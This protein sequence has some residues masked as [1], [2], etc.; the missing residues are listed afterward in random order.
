MNLDSSIIQTEIQL[1]N[2]VAGVSKAVEALA[3]ELP[4]ERRVE[5]FQHLGEALVG[6]QRALALVQER[7]QHLEQQQKAG[8]GPAGS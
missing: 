3:N 1:I 4:Q 2:A 8:D 5:V 6:I 7:I